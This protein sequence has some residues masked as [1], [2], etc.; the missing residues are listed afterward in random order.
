MTVNPSI[1]QEA[2]DWIRHI[3]LLQCAYLLGVP[4]GDEAW[5]TAFIHKMADDF[6]RRVGPD[7]T[8]EMGGISWE[9]DGVRLYAEQLIRDEKA[10]WKETVRLWESLRK[11]AAPASE[12]FWQKQFPKP[13]PKSDS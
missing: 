6:I 12:N 4:D 3:A 7:V 10:N 11:P 2:R 5:E 13:V 1:D 9:E 8:Y